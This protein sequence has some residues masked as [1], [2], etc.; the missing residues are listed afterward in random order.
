MSR[1]R[2]AG[3]SKSD[4]ARFC[5]GVISDDRSHEIQARSSPDRPPTAMIR[6]ET[7]RRVYSTVGKQRPSALTW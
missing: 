3:V 7:W 2:V 4:E 5:R 1:L 6:T